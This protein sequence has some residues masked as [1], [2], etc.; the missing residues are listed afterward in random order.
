GDQE[1]VRVFSLLGAEA[2]QFA[3]FGAFDPSVR[4]AVSLAAADTNSNRTDEVIAGAPEGS[5]GT[6]RLLYGFRDCT[7]QPNAWHVYDPAES[8]VYLPPYE[9][10]VSPGFERAL[11]RP[12]DP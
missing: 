5:G 10:S 12:G 8:E 6:V 7:P 2:K 9:F 11:V 3:E 1:P 4:G